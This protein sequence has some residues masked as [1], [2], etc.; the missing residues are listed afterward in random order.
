[1]WN[2]NYLC[3]FGIPGQKWG[4]RRYQNEDGT[5][6]EEGK[7]R[8]YDSLTDREKKVYRTLQP[9]DRAR[10]NKKLAEGKSFEQAAKELNKE[11]ARKAAITG[12]LFGAAYLYMN[13]ITRPMMKA[14]ARFMSK[15]IAGS[16]KA[17]FRTIKNTN[18]AQR[19]SLWLKK[20]FSRRSITK[21]GA[22]VLNKNDFSVKDIPFG[23]YL[24]NA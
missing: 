11:A 9:N 17:L 22:V 18:A 2:Y 12:A 16:G 20:A 15:I 10:L 24:R 5:L 3:H 21:N 4:V 6:T 14:G 1:M 7:A 8:Y 13:P 19:G 23:G